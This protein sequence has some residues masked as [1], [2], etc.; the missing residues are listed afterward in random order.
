[1]YNKVPVDGKGA[2]AERGLNPVEDSGPNSEHWYIPEDS[3]VWKWEVSN[4]RGSSWEWIQ[5]NIPSEAWD[6]RSG[7]TVYIGNVVLSGVS[8]GGG[9]NFDNSGNSA[10]LY[11]QRGNQGNWGC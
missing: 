2:G 1:M 7:G 9:M 5:T 11:Y 10:T 4:N 3:T 8:S 6:D